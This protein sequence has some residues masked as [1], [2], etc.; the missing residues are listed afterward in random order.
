MALVMKRRCILNCEGENTMY[1]LPRGEEEK[2]QWLRFIFNAIPEQY[3]P[4]LLL[5]AVH[6]TEDCFLNWTQ[7]YCGYSKRLQLKDGAVPTLLSPHRDTGVYEYRLKSRG[8]VASVVNHVASQTDPPCSHLPETRT[9]GTQLAM[10]SPHIFKSTATQVRV[11]KRDCGVGT[12]TLP[13]NSP[14]LL[15][16]PQLEKRLSKR[17]RLTL[18]DEEEEEDPSES[19]RSTVVQHKNNLT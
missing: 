1:T 3:N 16:Q 9:V 12:E 7:F 2:S 6:F 4:R 10:A 19:I 15:M 8:Q 11:M 5:C 13:L 14:L 17:P 18:A